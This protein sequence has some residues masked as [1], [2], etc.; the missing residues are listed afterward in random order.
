MVP[1]KEESVPTTDIAEIFAA[2]KEP[3]H[4]VNFLIPSPEENRRVRGV[5]QE[6]FPEFQFVM[7]WSIGMEMLPLSGGKGNALMRLKEHLNGKVHTVVAAGDFE[8]DISL[9]QKAD[10]GYAVANACEECKAAAELAH[11]A[12]FIEQMPD[13]YDTMLT[14]DGANLSQGQ[15]QLLAIARAAVADPPVLILDEATSVIKSDV[16]VL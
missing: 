13:G 3:W 10:I 8:N 16:K 2:D 14:N 9:L 6:K 11:A 5:M 15:R 1:W 7:S 4:K 12:E